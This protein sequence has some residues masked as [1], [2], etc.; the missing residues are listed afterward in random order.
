MKILFKSKIIARRFPD[1]ITIE[2]SQNYSPYLSNI[3]NT[4]IVTQRLKFKTGFIPLSLFPYWNGNTNK[5][6]SLEEL[7]DMVIPFTARINSDLYNIS[8]SESY[9]FPSYFIN[10][11][12]PRISKGNYVERPI[13]NGYLRNTVVFPGDFSFWSIID[14]HYGVGD[15]DKRR[16][17]ND[18]YISRL[19]LTMVIDTNG[20][21][22]SQ[23]N[24]YLDPNS[25][26]PI[27]KDTSRIKILL[28]RD[29]VV[30]PNFNEQ[31]K[32]FNKVF[33]SLRKYDKIRTIVIENL[34]DY[35]YE[36]VEPDLSRLTPEKFF[37]LKNV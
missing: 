17:L 33:K 25:S 28:D 19:L 6:Y 15:D 3:N 22:R 18:I 4:P 29:F 21:S 13:G 16:I 34:K 12:T 10:N 1:G 9:S 7:S 36:E 27:L 23:S 30:N 35:L 32:E 14:L 5:E 11:Y 26:I 31:F 20:L 37:S 8:T 2:P 24:L